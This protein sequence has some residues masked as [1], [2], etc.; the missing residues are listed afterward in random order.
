MSDP[1]PDDPLVPEIA[2]LLRSNKKLHDTNATEWTSL[3]ASGAQ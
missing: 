2:E 1:N 3:Y